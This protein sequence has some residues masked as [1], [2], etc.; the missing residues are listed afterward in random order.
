MKLYQWILL[1]SLSLLG[2]ESGDET[3][4]KQINKLQVNAGA[5][6]TIRIGKSAKLIGQ[7]K[8]FDGEIV[9]YQWKEDSTELSSEA[10][11]IIDSMSEGEHILTFSVEDNAGN[12]NS[13]NVVVNIQSEGEIFMQN[14]LNAVNRARSQPRDCK[15]GRG[16]LSA[17][18]SLKWNDGIYR[19]ALEHSKDMALSD[20]YE[21]EGSGTQSDITGYKDNTKST[22]NTRIAINSEKKWEYASENIIAGAGSLEKMMSKWLKSPPHCANIMNKNWTH[23][24]MATYRENSSKWVVYWTQNF[25]REV[26]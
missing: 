21:H 13:D 24:G 19:A 2:C 22:H 8:D 5:D 14:Y 17:A 11:F 7:V 20:T 18:K 12:R 15:N 4:L 1:V 16:I 9:Q 23:F 10:E 25:A 26:K 3:S 6:I